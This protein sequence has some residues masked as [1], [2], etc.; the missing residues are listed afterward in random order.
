[1]FGVPWQEWPP[2][3]W[4]PLA[5]ALCVLWSPG[6]G[7]YWEQGSPGLRQDRASWWSVP[8]DRT[9]WVL[10]SSCSHSSD[11]TLHTHTYIILAFLL[12][13]CIPEYRDY[14]QAKIG[15][16]RIINNFLIFVPKVPKIN[17]HRLT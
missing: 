10:S 11:C 3:P 8:Q 9:R 1:M 5:R 4:P 12:I 15:S 7:S 17:R 13:Y 14:S 16:F 2:E 6:R